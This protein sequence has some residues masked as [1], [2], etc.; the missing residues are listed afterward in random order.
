MK[1][2]QPYRVYMEARAYY[3]VDVEASDEDEAQRLAMQMS[4]EF[5]VSVGGSIVYDFE[6]DMGNLDVVK[7]TEG[8]TPAEWETAQVFVADGMDAREAVRAAVIL[9]SK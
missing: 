3:E 7:V 8:L 5:A 6:V 2:K 4:H 1:S 9:L